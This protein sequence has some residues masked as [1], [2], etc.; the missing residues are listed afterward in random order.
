[1]VTSSSW[2]IL[3]MDGTVCGFVRYL[4]DD[5]V[6]TYICELLVDK[7]Y[8]RNGYASLMLAEMRKLHPET[9]IEL[10]SEADGFYDNLKFRVVGSGRRKSLGDEF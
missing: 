8:R 3:E 2:L 4:T 5:V 10:I 1:M 9:R 6:T 7:R